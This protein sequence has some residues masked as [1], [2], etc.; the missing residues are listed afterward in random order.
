MNIP[1]EKCGCP[2]IMCLERELIRCAYQCA[3]SGKI[4][5]NYAGNRSQMGTIFMENEWQPR[6]RVSR[7]IITHFPIEI[8]VYIYGLAYKYRMQN[9]VED[10]ER[11]NFHWMSFTQECWERLESMQWCQWLESNQKEY[12]DKR[13]AFLGKSILSSKDIN[14]RYTNIRGQLNLL[15]MYQDAYL[16]EQILS[17]TV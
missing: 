11:W 5:I 8:G 10:A 3:Y 13:K 7:S 15:N 9:I 6:T 17:N 12:F 4:L 14:G 1:L 16:Y 2:E